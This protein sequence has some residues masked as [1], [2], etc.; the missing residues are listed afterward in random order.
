ML[1]G[2]GVIRATAW[3]L[4]CEMVCYV[5]RGRSRCC[6]SATRPVATESYRQL[7]V[8]EQQEGDE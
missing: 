5:F 6:D 3:C 4:M 8:I 1:Q 2:S 7:R